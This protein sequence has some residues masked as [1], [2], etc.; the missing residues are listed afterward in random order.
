VKPVEKSTGFFYWL[1]LGIPMEI[2]TLFLT[3]LQIFKD[4]ITSFR[5]SFLKISKKRRCFCLKSANLQFPLTNDNQFFIND[6]SKMN[7]CI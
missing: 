2:N 1:N 3:L 6:N 5:T 4:H 7:H